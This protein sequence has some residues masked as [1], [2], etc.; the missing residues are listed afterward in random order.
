[1]S[2]QSSTIKKIYQVEK[3]NEDIRQTILTNIVKMLTERKLLN[4]KDQDKNIESIIKKQSDDMIYTL[5]LPDNNKFAIKITPHKVTAINRSFGISEFLVAHKNHPKIIVVREISKKARQ[6][7]INNFT[8]T[9]IFIEEEMMINIVEHDIVP[10]HE[11]LT[12]EEANTFYI[13]F[14][15]K[16]KNMPKILHTDPI[17]KYYNMQ[18]NNIC[19][20][21]RPSAKS[22]LSASYRLVIKGNI[23]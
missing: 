2:Y 20:I 1:M 14:G 10:K 22:G 12:E 11:L 13:D 19:R 21:L 16:K 15:C 17:A 8:K 7:I 18:P 23:K 5:D 3:N 6:Y 9:E 4:I